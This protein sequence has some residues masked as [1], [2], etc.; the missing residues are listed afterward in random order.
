MVIQLEY[1]WRSDRCTDFFYANG[2]QRRN[3]EQCAELLG[4]LANRPLPCVM[5]QPLQCCR[6]QEQRHIQLHPH[7]RRRHVDGLDAGQNPGDQ[8]TVF[9][10]GRVA[11]VGQFVIGGAVYVVKNGTRQTSPCKSAELSRIETMLE[12]HGT[13]AP[14]LTRF[15]ISPREYP[16]SSSI[17][18]QSAPRGRGA[19]GGV[20]L[21]RCAGAGCTTSPTCMNER[22]A[23]LC[24]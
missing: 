12:L 16:I 21:N 1:L 11:P 22:R 4:G 6:R 18:T 24:P 10:G 15:S 13:T 20:L 7:H 2:R 19:S 8:V 5:K 23:W 9:V 14:V 3:A 17:S